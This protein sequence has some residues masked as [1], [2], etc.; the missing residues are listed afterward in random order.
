MIYCCGNVLVRI[1]RR[2]ILSVPSYHLP[3][4]LKPIYDVWLA[5][6]SYLEPKYQAYHSLHCN[7]PVYL[8]HEDVEFIQTP[9]RTSERLPERHQKANSR[10]RLF[11]PRQRLGICGLFRD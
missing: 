7:V 10:E 3:W 6:E 2:Q 1:D 4:R 11:T 9:D 5:L 8:I